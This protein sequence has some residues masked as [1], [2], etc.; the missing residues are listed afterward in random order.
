V[1]RIRELR[2]SGLS[3][4]EIARQTGYD[5]KTIR[6]YLKTT[7]PPR[8]GPRRPRPP[9]EL[10]YGYAKLGAYH[11]YLDRRMDEGV[12]SAVVLFRELQA[13]GYDGGYT[14]VKDYIRPKRKDAKELAVRRYETPPGKQAQVDWAQ[15][16]TYEEDGERH[17]LYAFVFTLGCSRALFAD[18]C[19]SQSMSV[20]LRMHEAAFLELGGVPSEILYDWMK[21]VASGVDERGEVRWNPKFLDFASHWGFT[22]KLCHPYRPQTKGKIESSVGY[23]RK[24]FVTGLKAVSVSDTS[25]QLKS[26]V[27]EVANRRVHGTTHRV[28]LQ[29]WKEERA[30]LQPAAGRPSYPY[31]EEET[32]KVSRDAFVAYHANRLSVPW[33]LAGSQVTVREGLERIEVVKDGATVAVHPLPLGKHQVLIQKE[34]HAGMPYA[35]EE[36]NSHKP[37]L[38]LLR[39]T[40]EVEIRSLSV[41]D[42]LLVLGGAQ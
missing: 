42:D 15:I 30:Y 23:V 7:E 26:W 25:R 5:R 12:W 27:W 2:D 8:Y 14:R 24:S 34:H 19:T 20:F 38:R 32:R 16:G 36:A 31:V 6:K 37:M 17:R 41:Y 21:T 10:P 3:V 1:E 22:P 29:A 4:S 40:P 9:R 39:P 28:V 13:Q 18:A 33:V 35:L 11:P